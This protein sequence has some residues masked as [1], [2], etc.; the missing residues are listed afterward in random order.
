MAVGERHSC[1]LSYDGLVKCWGSNQHGQADA[2]SIFG[3]T[4]LVAG[5]NFT[6]AYHQ[7]GRLDCWGKFGP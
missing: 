1:A 2:P 5:L 7:E 4:H 3:Y 6:C